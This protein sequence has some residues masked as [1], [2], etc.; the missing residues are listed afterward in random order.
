MIRIH[1]AS[2]DLVEIEGSVREE[3]DAYDRPRII[4]VG[5]KIGGGIRAVVEYAPGPAAVWR[6]AVEPI[7]EWVPIPWPV[8]IQLSPYGYS[9]ELIIECPSDTPVTWDGKEAGDA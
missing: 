1:G 2:D 6:I 9:P 3:L 8:R 7:D 4:T 5:D